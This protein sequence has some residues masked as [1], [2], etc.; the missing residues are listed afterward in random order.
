M[1]SLS[2]FKNIAGLECGGGIAVGQFVGDCVSKNL[3][4]GSVLALR[5]IPRALALES[6]GFAV[7][8]FDRDNQVANVRRFDLSDWLVPKSREN[9]SFQPPKDI[10]RRIAFNSWCPMLILNNLQ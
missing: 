10:S 5:N 4:D 2:R 1:L 9:V 6:P 7:P 8:L 3:A